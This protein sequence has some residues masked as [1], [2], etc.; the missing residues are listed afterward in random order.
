M[1]KNICSNAPDHWS[2]S[3]WRAPPLIPPDQESLARLLPRFLP[4]AD[5]VVGLGESIQMTYLLP[6]IVARSGARALIVP[7]ENLR[8]VPDRAVR[9][10]KTAMEE[11]GVT[12]AL[13]KPFCSL[14][15]RTYNEA[16]WREEYRDA[17]I[18]E[19]ARYFGRPEFRILFDSS[20]CVTRCEVRRDVACGFAHLLADHLIGCSIDQVERVTSQFLREHD[21]PNARITDQ[22][23]GASLRQ[24]ADSIV[25]DAVR[26]EVEPF[27]V[28][29]GEALIE[30]V[31]IES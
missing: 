13:P 5:L 17:H 26:R 19:F 2:V 21:C 11:T 6:E 30:S 3:T 14:T 10:L 1:A 29:D 8:W 12:V 27:L 18:S 9:Y 20:Q 31:P 24:V 7:I 23:Y 28:Q 15:M 16:S 25:R 22:D 4:A